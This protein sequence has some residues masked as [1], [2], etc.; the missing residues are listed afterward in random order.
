MPLTHSIRLKIIKTEQAIDR[1]TDTDVHCWTDTADDRDW[2]VHSLSTKRCLRFTRPDVVKMSVN[3]P[4]SA[5]ILWPRIHTYPQSEH[6]NRLCPTNTS[7]TQHTKYTAVTYYCIHLV[8]GVGTPTMTV[9][10][11]LNIPG[12]PS[13]LT[14]AHCVQYT[15][16]YYESYT[17][18]Q[19]GI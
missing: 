5:V 14:P 6:L 16:I 1:Q 11:E 4:T 13:S 10:G 7:A 12:K 3:S 15:T 2:N 8:G 17:C 19:V 9:W 18:T